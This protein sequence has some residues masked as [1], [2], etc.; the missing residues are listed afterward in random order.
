VTTPATILDTATIKCDG[1]VRG[2]D[3]QG[4][5]VYVVETI[6]GP[7]WLEA[8]YEWMENGNDFY[9]TVR[10]FGLVRKSAAG[11]TTLL[12]CRRFSEED[13]KTAQ[14]LLEAL[15]MG[16]E[17]IRGSHTC[18]NTRR[19]NAWESNYRAG[20]SGPLRRNNSTP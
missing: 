1:S 13:A 17:T 16:H 9:L 18:F 10:N 19:P 15:F 7:L 20:G 11:S 6:E 4:I 3:D 12:F 2:P 8:H 14:V 5:E